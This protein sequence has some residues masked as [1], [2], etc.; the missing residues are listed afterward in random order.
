MN[1]IVAHESFSKA[2]R[3]STTAAM[4]CVSFETGAL[5]APFPAH[6]PQGIYPREAPQIARTGAV[7]A[8][9]GLAKIRR[10]IART[11]QILMRFDCS[12]VLVIAN[13][14]EH[15]AS[16]LPVAAGEALRCEIAALRAAA[17]VLQDDESAALAAALSARG[18]G[19]NAA[20]AHVALTVC[21]SV[22]WRCGDLERFHAVERSRLDSQP[23]RMQAISALFDLAL[24]AAVAL[25]QMRFNAARLL[26]TDAL[27]VGRRH[28][29]KHVPADAFPACLIAQVLY[30]QGQVDEAEALVVARMASIRQ[31]CTLESAL[32][33]HRLLAQIAVGR[34]QASRARV[35]LREAETLAEQRGWPR[36]RAASLAQQIEIETGS[37]RVEQAA[38]CLQRLAELAGEERASHHV[39]LEIARFHTI[40]D[41]RVALARSPCTVDIASL[42]QVH[43][44]MVWRGSLYAAVPVALLLVEALLVTEQRGEAV[45][46]LVGLLRLAP[47]VGL[48]QTLVNCSARVAELIDAIV[49]QRIVPVSDTRELLPYAGMLLVH[50]QRDA[51]LADEPLMA[52][53]TPRPHTGTHTGTGLSERE[54]RI[55]ELMGSGLSNKQIAG[56][57]C[58]APETVKSHAK[59]LYAKL[60]V[61]NRTEAVTLVTR[62]GL[63]PIPRSLSA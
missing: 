18:S 43:R 7:R 55:V 13:Q 58:I 38:Q 4:P 62:L 9:I 32:R 27:E 48:H 44:D 10:D 46:V 25:D 26:A 11:W 57:L 40:A 19:A 61:R 59:H 20:T 36:L 8:D 53:A 34:G 3:T 22:Y 56:E 12:E 63:I 37:G 50:R 54:R 35:I 33:A 16:R 41:A 42:R 52:E 28:I 23:G 6:L 2:V 15:L 45:E 5:R 14:L 1:D 24:D 21:R 51:N 17:L 31:C 30:E 49:Q 29:G 47:S 60:S 39:S